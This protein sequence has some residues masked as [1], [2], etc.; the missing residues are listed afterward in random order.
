MSMSELDGGGEK[1]SKIQ[2]GR[3]EGEEEAVIKE[4]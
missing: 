2:V 1:D 3:R 4:Y